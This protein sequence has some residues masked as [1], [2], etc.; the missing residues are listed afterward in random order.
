L[1]Y[2]QTVPGDSMKCEEPRSTFV[3]VSQFAAA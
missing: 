2:A 3:A 1:L